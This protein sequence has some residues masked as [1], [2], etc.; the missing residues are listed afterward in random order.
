MNL[1]YMRRDDVDGCLNFICDDLLTNLEVTMFGISTV[2]ELEGAKLLSKN[3]LGVSS[4]NVAEELKMFGKE[5]WCL[6]RSDAA[7]VAYSLWL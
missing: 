5:C 3:P 6:R 7:L 4:S 1:G 2:P